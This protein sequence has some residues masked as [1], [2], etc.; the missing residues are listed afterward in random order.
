MRSS[1]ATKVFWPMGDGQ[2]MGGLSRKHI[3]QACEASLRRLGIET[4]DLYQIH[5]FDADTPIDET[6]RALDDLVRHGK[7]RYIGASSG[8]R[9]ADDEGAEHVR[10][11]WVGAVRLDA[12]SLQPPV[13]RGGARDDSAVHGGGDRGDPVVAARARASGAG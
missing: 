12:E 6:L 3:T 11:K 7:V 2:N 13:P 5:R 4:I 9:V 10:A 1:I 8:L